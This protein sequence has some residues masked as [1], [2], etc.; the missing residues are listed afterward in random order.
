MEVDM[1][2]AILCALLLSITLPQT[3]F[4]QDL[5]EIYAANVTSM[6]ILLNLA[7]V[8]N[9]N[10]VGTMTFDGIE[11]SLTGRKKGDQV[12]GI[13]TRGA[14]KLQFRAKYKQQDLLFTISDATETET[15][16][17]T[18]LE[19]NEISDVPTKETAYR[20]EKVIIN[21]TELSHAQID[22]LEAMYGFKPLPGNYWYDATSGLYGV[23]GFSAYGFM[24]AGHDFG[25]L[26]SNASNGDSNVFVNGRQLPQMEWL[27]WSQLLGYVIQPGRYWLDADGNAGYEGNLT[28]VE[29]LYLAAQRNTAAQNNAFNSRSGGGGGDNFWSSRFSAGNYD[30]GNQRGY[31]SVPGHGPVGYGF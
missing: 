16:L 6:A 22:E 29:N 19:S 12:T 2:R 4:A 9:D 14:E 17:F 24:F 11:Y 28:P 3:I 5:T 1:Y 13:L 7:Q 8:Q 31:V 21:G 20:D 10:I 30:Q 15:I 23:M 27:F 26:D 25:K 18:R